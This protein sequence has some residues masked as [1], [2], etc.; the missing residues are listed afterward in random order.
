M[1][2]GR[3]VMNPAEARAKASE[4]KNI[5]NE[6]ET[7]LNTVSR[8][9]QEIDNTETGIYQGNRR[10]AQLRAELDSFRATF[11][12]AH[13]QIVKSANDIITIANTAE[14]E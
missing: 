10:P 12:L 1:A 11:N 9:M 7:L 3:L 5:A 14:A 6:L 8:K 4:M 2:D 13:E